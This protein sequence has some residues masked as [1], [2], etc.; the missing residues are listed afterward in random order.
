M[1]VL[2][3]MYH[4]TQ[5]CASVY[6][7]LLSAIA[8]YNL[9]QWEPQTESASRYSNTATRQLHKTRTTQAS[10]VLATLSSLVSSV[11]LVVAV[12]SGRNTKPFLL[13]AA[14]AGGL[15]LAYNHIGNFWRSRATVPL[16]SRYNEG[17]RSTR[18]ML[19]ALGVLMVS[20]AASTV[21]YLFRAIMY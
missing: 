5:A 21:I 18:Q 9:R 19:Q 10:G 8:I 3:E 1:S 13:S 15:F 7:A 20:W 17:I 2:L 6:L 12:S 14:N 4:A 11:I 16:A